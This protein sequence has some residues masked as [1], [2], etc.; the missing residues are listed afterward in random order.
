MP[1]L[2]T[3][4][5][6]VLTCLL[7][8]ASYMVLNAP[9]NCYFSPSRIKAQMASLAIKIETYRKDHGAFPETLTA[10]L[11]N[12]SSMAYA[13][14]HDFNDPWGKPFIFRQLDANSF[15]LLS[16]GADQML[17][18]RD[19]NQDIQLLYQEGAWSVDHAR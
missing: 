19:T 5:F 10:L 11:S 3:Q 17:G 9:R 13:K 12:E 1:S 14:K 2:K 6:V 15:V 16:L 8:L 7:S 4:L 18:G